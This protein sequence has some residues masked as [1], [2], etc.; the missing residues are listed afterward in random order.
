[1]DIW[2]KSIQAERIERQRQEG[3]WSGHKSKEASAPGA[4]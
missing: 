4:E 3:A 2:V 1:M